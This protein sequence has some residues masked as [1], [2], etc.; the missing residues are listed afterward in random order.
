LQAQRIPVT[1]PETVLQAAGHRRNGAS[2]RERLITQQAAKMPAM[3]EAPSHTSTQIV[4]DVKANAV[5]A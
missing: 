4:T 3:F 1:A 2:A 5:W